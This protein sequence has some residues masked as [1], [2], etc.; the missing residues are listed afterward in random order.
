MDKP[1]TARLKLALEEHATIKSAAE[2]S[3]ASKVT[4]ATVSNWLGNK[5][6]EDQAKGAIGVKLSKALGIRAE[7]LFTGEKPMRPMQA[8]DGPVEPISNYG[9]TVTDPSPARYQRVQ[10][11]GIAMVDAEGFWQEL[12]ESKGDEFVEASTSD[13]NAYAVRILGRRF[14]PV[15]DS[16]QCILMAPGAP[17]RMNKR[18]LVRLADGRHTV[19]VYLNHQEGLWMFTSLTDA[20]DVLELRDDQVAA[21]ERVMAVS[22]SE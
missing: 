22:D 10:V 14:Y 11:R 20:N 12:E 19:R 6:Q 7:W 18:V 1:I 8:T 4:E 3:R 13:P 21:V 15:I 5:V 9:A 17:L 2:L 16:G